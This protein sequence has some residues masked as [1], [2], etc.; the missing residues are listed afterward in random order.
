LELRNKAE[1][2]REMKISPQRVYQI[3]KS[4]GWNERVEAYDNWLQGAEDK[5]LYEGREQ[6]AREHLEV[7][8][9]AR[10]VADEALTA[11]LQSLRKEGS[12]TEI[13][14]RDALAF[15]EKAVTLERLVTGEATDRVETFDLSRLTGDEAEKL[16]E[17]LEKLK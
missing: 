5:V 3:A 9:K 2:A 15:L 11:L 4:W 1:V 12:E 6:L 10:A 14:P 16:L 13:S 8:R 17:T 7:I